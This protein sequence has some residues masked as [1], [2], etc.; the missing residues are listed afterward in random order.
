MLISVLNK[1]KVYEYAEQSFMSFALFVISVILMLSFTIRANK[2]FFNKNDIELTSKFPLKNRDIIISKLI[3]L[4]GNYFIVCF[5]FT[6]PLFV[7]YG[8]ITKASIG[9]YFVTMLYP[10]ITFFFDM[11][12]SLILLC[13]Y[14]IIKN[15]LKNRFVIKFICYLVILAIATYLY[16]K[17]LTVYVNLVVGGDVLTLFTQDMINKFKAAMVFEL[18]ASPFIK[19]I[20][21]KKMIFLLYIPLNFVIFAYRIELK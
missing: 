6:Y 1:I 2:L 16:S 11:G 10:I 13:P 8:I 3:F 14:T 17:V 18:P 4:F 19:Y 15:Q 9:F 12:I 20:V 7:A 21:D 5:L